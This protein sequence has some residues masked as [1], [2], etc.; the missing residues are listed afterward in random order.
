MAI[1]QVRRLT[2]E[3]LPAVMH[4]Q[5]FCYST[6]YIEPLQTML[7]HID[8]GHPCWIATIDE[9]PVGYLLCATMSNDTFPAPLELGGHRITNQND[10]PNN[11]LYLH[12]LAVLPSARG[13]G[14][15]SL[16]L[17]MAWETAAQSTTLA[18]CALVAV[19]KSK[20][21]WE[22]LGFTEAQT[23]CPEIDTK[24]TRYGPDACYMWRSLRE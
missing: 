6:E 12:D 8:I 13:L 1:P 20:A 7:D 9:A 2:R 23:R 16:L 19:Q 21:F 17:N 24:L 14:I 18:R 3:D 10:C 11:W 22:S 15:S 4:I 5:G